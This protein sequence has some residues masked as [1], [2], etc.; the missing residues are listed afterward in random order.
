MAAAQAQ[1]FGERSHKPPSFPVEKHP[2]VSEKDYKAAL[3]KIPVSKQK[4]D[5]W[6]V[7]RPND[8][9]KSASEPQKG[10]KKAN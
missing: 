3:E 2:A 1:D 7:A 9:A 6:G 10:A 4:Y 5:P 8:S